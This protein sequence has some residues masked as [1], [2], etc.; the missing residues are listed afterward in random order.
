M[1][2]T[3]LDGE[4][5]VE[6]GKRMLTILVVAGIVIAYPI[7][8][9]IVYQV[10]KILDGGIREQDRTFML[11]LTALWPIGIPLI[12]TLAIP[13]GIYKLFCLY[14]SWLYAA[15]DKIG[16]RMM[17]RKLPKKSAPDP[18]PAMMTSEEYRR[19]K[20]MIEGFEAKLPV[21]ERE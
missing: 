10:E 5:V 7:V 21:C 1:V 13:L 4:T 2:R 3:G 6:K 20:P 14:L 19:L 17:A 12:V 9:A 8:S 18:S 11:V 15:A 16:D